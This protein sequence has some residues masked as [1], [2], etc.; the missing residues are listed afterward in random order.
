MDIKPVHN[1]VSNFKIGKKTKV[2]LLT[3]I[4][5]PAPVKTYVERAFTLARLLRFADHYDFN[6]TDLKRVRKVFEN[7]NGE[8]KIIITTEKDYMRLMQEN[9]K[10]IVETLPIYTLPIEIKFLHTDAE[11]AASTILDYA[12]KNT[13]NHKQHSVGS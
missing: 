5:D 13:A 9:L 6:E 4:A 11:I 10:P 3:G 1:V 7:I 8:E 12:R 2:L